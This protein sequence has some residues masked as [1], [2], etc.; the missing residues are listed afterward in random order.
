M[1][2]PL[3]TSAIA[4]FGEASSFAFLNTSTN[5]TA[6]FALT[7][8]CQH[9]LIPFSA[10]DVK[11]HTEACE[12]AGSDDFRLSL[13]T[14]KFLDKTF[15]DTEDSIRHLSASILIVISLLILIQALGLAYLAYYI[16]QVPTWTD[17]LDAMAVARI[18]NS[19]DKAD[20]PALGLVDRRDLEGLRGISALVGVGRGARKGSRSARW[21]I[22]VSVVDARGC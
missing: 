20:I 4:M 9:N 21:I 6:S 15:F 12:A 5:T 14:K 13:V 18:A 16:Y 17:M 8:A 22:V 1:S 19:L 11:S 10:F 7:Q 3:M 2:G